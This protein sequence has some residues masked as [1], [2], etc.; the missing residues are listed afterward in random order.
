MEATTTKGWREVSYV[1]LCKK[2]A[3][4]CNGPKG[5]VGVRVAYLQ[6]HDI[7]S[8]YKPIVS[9]P[10]GT[11]KLPPMSESSMPEDAICSNLKGFDADSKLYDHLISNLR[12][13]I[14]LEMSLKTCLKLR[15][16]SFLTSVSDYFL[17][18][19]CVLVR[20]WIRLDAFPRIMAFCLAISLAS[21]SSC[22]CDF[23][24]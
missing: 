7:R 21:E 17:F 16:S 15:R 23:R 11:M 8:V 4:Y 12:P 24:R 1:C 10:L 5:N 20:Y 6:V 2:M 22:V 18:H 19:T 9:K 14:Q 13:M 3:L